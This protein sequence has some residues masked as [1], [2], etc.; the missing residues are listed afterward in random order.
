MTHVIV[1][2]GRDF[3]D[4]KLLTESLDK[5]LAEYSDIEIVSGRA[6]GADT[7]GEEYAA[8]HNLPCATF[9]AKWNQFGK[10][11]GYIRNAQMLLHAEE[12]TPV[13]VAFWNGESRGTKHMI[14]IAT[15]KKAQVHIVRY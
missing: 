13:V 14:D 11:A 4:K 10:A 5:I 7:L 12:G 6:R 2:G 9:P 3:D 1:C 8:E 15:A